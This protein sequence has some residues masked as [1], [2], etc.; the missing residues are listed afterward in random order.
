MGKSKDP[1]L[2]IKTQD[3][4]K[5]SQ[6]FAEEAKKVSDKKKLENKKKKLFFTEKYE[7]D[8]YSKKLIEE[9]HAV[10]PSSPKKDKNF[11]LINPIEQ[12]KEV[13]I[14]FYNF[15]RKSLIQL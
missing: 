12:R 7:I 13:N 10:S 4:K 1:I 3:F 11:T 6:Q 9:N 5:L 14:I 8:G 15:I 2:K